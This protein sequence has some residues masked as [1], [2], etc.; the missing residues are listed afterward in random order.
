MAIHPTALV[1][2]GA[3]IDPSAE[4]GPYCIVGEGVSIGA[5]TRLKGHVFLEGPLTVGEDNIFYPY[6][7]VGVAPQD[8]KYKGERSETHIGNG[9]RIR[10]FVTIHRGTEGGG[11]VTSIGDDNLAMAYVHVAH[12][13]HVGNHTVLSHGATIGGH[14]V[15]ED[16][17]VIG[18][19]SGVHQFCRIGRHAMIGGYSVITQ[20]VLP[21][22][23]TASAREVHIFGA[24]RTGLDRRGFP[25]ATIDGLQKAFRLLTKSGLNTTQATERILAEVP[26]TPEREELLA[27]L[28][29]SERGFVK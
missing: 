8:L 23:M 6:S 7:T 26:E 4:I 15:V 29:A 19:Q 13:V 18:A 5:R 11:M 14:V 17:A 10:E 27:F 3:T 22:S 16:W 20:D 21:F 2:S 25:A 1:D 28:R 9:N 12:D 24:N